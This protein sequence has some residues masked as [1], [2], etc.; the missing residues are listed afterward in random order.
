M[1]P[2][3]TLIQGYRLPGSSTILIEELQCR[4]HCHWVGEGAEGKGQGFPL[5]HNSL[6]LTLLAKAESH[7][8]RSC[9]GCRERSRYPS[10]SSATTLV[11][12]P[13]HF[14]EVSPRPILRRSPC[15]AFPGRCQVPV[16]SEGSSPL[17]NPS[18][19]AT[20]RL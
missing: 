6:P 16:P 2:Y 4:H 18:R 10:S 19:R 17:H 13:C 12:V 15:N 11:V 7:G 20:I 3:R 8:H 1:A 14:K 9:K 5:L